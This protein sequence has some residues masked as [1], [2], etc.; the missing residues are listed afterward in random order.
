MKAAIHSPLFIQATRAVTE[1]NGRMVD[2][3]PIYVALAQ[4]R[5]IR[6]AQLEQQYSS[7]R[8]S[9]AMPGPPPGGRGPPL[10]GMFPPQPQFQPQ[11]YG[12]PGPMGPPPGRPN[13]PAMGQMYPPMVPRGMPAVS[14]TFIKSNA[15]SHDSNS[16]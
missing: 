13:G 10:P 6:K 1:M 12:G 9:P 3:K 15:K 8:L 5:D 2:N 4:L 7:P 16:V 14:S 11:F